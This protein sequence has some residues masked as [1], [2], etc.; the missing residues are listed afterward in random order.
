MRLTRIRQSYTAP[1]PRTAGEAGAA[2]G[3]EAVVE[4]EAAAGVAEAGEAT[5]SESVLGVENYAGMVET[6]RRLES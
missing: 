3:E 4:A 2:A 1:Y 6:I 5:A